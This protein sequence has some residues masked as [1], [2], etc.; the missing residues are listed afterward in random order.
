MSYIRWVS[1]KKLWWERLPNRDPSA[2]EEAEAELLAQPYASVFLV[3]DRE[4]L[5]RV[6]VAAS[7]IRRNKQHFRYVVIPEEAVRS[8]AIPVDDTPAN[9]PFPDVN[10][11]HRNLDVT[12]GGA[13]RLVE[14]LVERGIEAKEIRHRELIAWAVAMAAAGE[15]I[16]PDS[17]L[18][19][20]ASHP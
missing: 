4:S 11:M 12:G 3:N 2:I 16:P 17:W 8:L 20:R 9:T 18:L 14:W 7:A 15:P 1:N 10:S 13:R 6:A 5:Q 19:K